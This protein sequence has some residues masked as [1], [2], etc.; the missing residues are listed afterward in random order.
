MNVGAIYKLKAL[1]LPLTLLHDYK[2]VCLLFSSDETTCSLK[3]VHKN[4]FLKEL[5]DVTVFETQSATFECQLVD[6]EATVQWWFKGE[7]VTQSDK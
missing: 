6:D 1:T 7:K 2:R 4:K 5:E 3:V